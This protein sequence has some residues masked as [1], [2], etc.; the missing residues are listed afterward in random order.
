MAGTDSTRL[1]SF[2][3]S[4]SVMLVNPQLG[5]NI[6]MAAR[7]MANFGMFDLNLVD[8]REG[9]DQEKA[10]AAASGAHQTVENAPVFKTL[11]E[12][13]QDKHYVY[14]TTARPRGMTKDVM[15]PEQAG[16]DMRARIA[17]GEKV[18]ILF[19]RERTGLNNEEV[20]LADMIIT[21]PVNP[22]YASLNIAQAVL[23]V[24]YE[25]FKHEATSLGQ[26]TPE[27]AAIEGPGLQMPDTR[28]ATKDE[29][30]GFYGHLEAELD[31]AGFFKTEA[32]HPG[33]MRNIRNIY[34][35][36]NLSEQE[37]RSLRGMV[38][39]LTRAH[40]KRKLAREAQSKDGGE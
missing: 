20:S 7:A 31:A 22:A 19:G 26:A 11:P 29:L 1:T 36:A 3:P 34:A 30:Y 14:A 35:R 15:T 40:E 24:T 5:E 18:A 21:A 9:W 38:S 32:K 12:A 4:P 10:T 28:P 37:V 27:L 16:L 2:G 25:W 6:G 8:P 17:R 39:S 33:M 23:L 13:L